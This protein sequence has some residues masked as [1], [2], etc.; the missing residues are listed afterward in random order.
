MVGMLCARQDG[1]LRDREMELKAQIASVK[2]KGKEKSKSESDAGDEG[3]IVTEENI[4]HIVSTWTGIPVEKVSTNEFDKIVKMEE[5][6][7][8]CIIGQDE[9][10]IAIS[11]AIRRERVGLKN[12]NRPTSSFIF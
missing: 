2:E 3:P 5:T 1:E 7:H 10:V 6:L 9:A 12:I 11:R 8:H 4:E